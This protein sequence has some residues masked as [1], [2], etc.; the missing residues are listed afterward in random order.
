MRARSLG[1]TL[2]V[3][4]SC[5]RA[6]AP[7]AALPAADAGLPAGERCSHRAADPPRTIVE[8][9][10]GTMRAVFTDGA[11][12][13]LLVGAERSLAEPSA[14]LRT[15]D[16]VR[17]L[18]SPYRGSMDQA[19]ARWLEVALAASEPDLLAVAM[20]YTEGASAREEKGLQIAGDA[21]YGP[22][23][24][25]GVRIEGADFNDYLGIPWD[26]PDGTV[27]RPRP[28]LLHSLDCS[29]FQRMVW[30]Y[31]MGLPLARGPSDA[32]LARRAVQ[33][34]AS[35][36]GV[37]IISGAEPPGTRFDRVQ[38]GD[39]VFF[40]ADPDDGPAI[41]HVGMVLG[42]DQAGRTRFLSSR[43]GSNGPTLGDAHGASVLEGTGLYARAFRAARR[44]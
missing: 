32:A 41:D 11:R 5:A 24:D 15:R 30:G 27:D 22:L 33:M 2:L 35:T 29:G 7:D 16:W 25:A 42:R 23:A 18:P 13:V 37:V 31:R 21:D 10:C 3:A 4:A 26:Y 36:F 8:R 28:G 39:L 1:A 17:V 12:A 20:E 38:A 43:K 9:P 14:A 34:E 40:D 44:W 6:P 19:L